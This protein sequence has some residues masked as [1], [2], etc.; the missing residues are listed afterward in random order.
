M[1]QRTQA[2]LPV[3]VRAAAALLLM[4]GL[5]VLINA[6]LVGQSEGV[7]ALDAA[8][9]RPAVRALGTG[10]LALGLWRGARWA[11]WGTVVL[12]GLWLAAGLAAF[13]ALFSTGASD[14]LPSG[15]QW[16]LPAGIF[17]LGMTLGLLLIKTSR[18]VFRRPAV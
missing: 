6:V 14:R 11:W 13:I 2:M 1:A 10:L 15:T 12:G 9:P 18:A 3:E 5:S 8:L 7:P 16:F 17:L 4:Y